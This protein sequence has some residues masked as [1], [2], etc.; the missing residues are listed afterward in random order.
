VF[1]LWDMMWEKHVYFFD[2]QDVAFMR[3]GYEGLPQE[4]VLSPF[5]YN[6]HTHL[7]EACLHPLCLILQDADDLVVYISG[8]HVET[9]R[10]CLQ[11]SLTR[12][13]AWFGDL[14]LSLSAKRD[15]F[16][17]KH[18]NPYFSVRLGQTALQNVTEFKY[19]GIIFDRKQTW[20]QPAEYIQRRC[21]ARVNFM[22][23]IAGQSWGAHPACLLVLYKRT[24][25]F[26]IEYG[27]VCFSGMSDC[28]MRRLERIQWR[29]GRIC[30]GLMRSTHVM[31]VKVLAG[32]PPI[33][34]R[35]S[36]L[37]ILKKWATKR[38]SKKVP[39]SSHPTK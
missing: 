3:K 8:K 2:G 10:D 6:F 33:R 13:I 7:V 5:M 17:R 14:G 9:V 29:A 15:G 26:A 35:F 25:R 32:L 22:K 4:L 11:T 19:L 21:H 36:F 23:S 1:L 20:R 28:H 27:G 24:V 34:Q 30:F 38:I 31:S 18:E 16:S 37:Y 39:F 12:L